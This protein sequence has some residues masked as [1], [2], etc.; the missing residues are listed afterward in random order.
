MVTGTS[1]FANNGVEGESARKVVLRWKHSGRFVGG[2]EMPATDLYG[3]GGVV[4]ICQ[5]DVVQQAAADEVIIL[6]LTGSEL[7]R[8]PCV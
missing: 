3:H 2:R 4:R 5:P 1:T 8:S 6:L 7:N